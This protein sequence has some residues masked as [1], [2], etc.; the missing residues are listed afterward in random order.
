M[1]RPSILPI[2]AATIIAGCTAMRWVWNW[3]IGVRD[4]PNT[5]QSW[6]KM[7]LENPAHG[8]E[9]PVPSVAFT[10]PADFV[11]KIWPLV[12]FLVKNKGLP[13]DR[14]CH[15]HD[16]MKTSL[17]LL[18]VPLIPILLGICPRLAL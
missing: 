4:V 9:Y 3:D 13:L 14:P 6:G 15:Y 10:P 12:R 5:Q 8:G 2:A 1:P 16:T 7:V 11:A 18:P 17:R